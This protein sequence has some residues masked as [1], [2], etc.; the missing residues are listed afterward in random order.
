MNKF[1]LIF[2]F[3]LVFL[4]TQAQKVKLKEGSLK[5]LKGQT[6]LNFN[7]KGMLVE[8]EPEKI[9]IQ[10][11]F[12]EKEE[13]SLGAGKQWM[14]AWETTDRKKIYEVKLLEYFNRQMVQFH[15]K[16]TLG[17]NEAPYTAT[18]RTM[19]IETI[20]N[21]FTANEL[22]DEIIFTEKNS[23]KILARST[24]SEASENYFNY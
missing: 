17:N 9:Y 7:Y 4:Y 23:S 10:K 24:I 14:N 5:F 6:E 21:L 20:G 15:L 22:K 18:I 3:S 2:I 1:I 16:G 13:D 19:D 8:G 12:K 11:K